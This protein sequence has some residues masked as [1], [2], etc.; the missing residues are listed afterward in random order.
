M[1][2]EGC[3]CG[4]AHRCIGDIQG[5]LDDVFDYGGR[6]VHPHVFRFA[7]CWVATAE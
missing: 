7:P 6:R 3:P 5:R 4:S 1:L 2:A